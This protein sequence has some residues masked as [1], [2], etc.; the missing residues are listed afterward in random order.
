MLGE[1]LS[2]TIVK[3]SLSTLLVL[4][5]VCVAGVIYAVYVEPKSLVT[6]RHQ[7]EVSGLLGKKQR[8]YNRPI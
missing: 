6:T 8:P 4:I 2:L 3:Y 1:I 5:I 7:L